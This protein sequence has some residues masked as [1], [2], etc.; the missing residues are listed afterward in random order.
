MLEEDYFQA[1]RARMDQA[2]LRTRDGRGHISNRL[3]HHF[4]L[5]PASHHQR[6]RRALFQAG[7]KAEFLV[8]HDDMRES[9]RRQGFVRI[10]RL[11]QVLLG[12]TVGAHVQAR[13]PGIFVER[14]DGMVHGFPGTDPEP[15]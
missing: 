12:D 15:A 10:E 7:R 4:I 8:L 2:G 5:V 13:P 14:F 1:L 9:L 3:M 6:W 11:L